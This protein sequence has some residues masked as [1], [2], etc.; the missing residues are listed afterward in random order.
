MKCNF[1]LWSITSNEPRVD[2]D[3]RQGQSEK[4]TEILSRYTAFVASGARQLS[5]ICRACS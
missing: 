3:V 2:A 5:L 1:P 4:R